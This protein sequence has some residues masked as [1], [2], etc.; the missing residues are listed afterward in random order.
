MTTI[1]IKNSST[2][3][4]V[5]TDGDLVTAELA[6]N[7]ANK[8]LYTKDAGGDVFKV[9]GSTQ[10]GTTANRPAAPNIGEFFYDTDESDFYYYDGTSWEPLS[11]EAGGKVSIGDAPPTDPAPEA[12]D[13]WFDT[14]SAQLYV[15]Y[16]DADSSQWIPSTPTDT[17]PGH[18]HVWLS[19]S[20]PADAELGQLWYDLDSGRMFVY[21]TNA[22]AQFIWVQ[23]L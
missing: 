23:N 17:D 8:V 20:P 4:K 10:S 16:T 22:A 14:E 2:L 7:L 5:P 18:A 9:A 12:G 15:Y 11:Q 6:L 1:K 19:T 3:N 21:T 13:M